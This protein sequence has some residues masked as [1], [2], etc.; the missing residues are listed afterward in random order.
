L[1]AAR[2]KFRLV[3]RAGAPFMG[4]GTLKVLAELPSGQL[5]VIGQSTL[6]S[7]KPNERDSQIYYIVRATL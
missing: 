6:Q 4:G 7:D 5:L 3:P 2:V 1:I